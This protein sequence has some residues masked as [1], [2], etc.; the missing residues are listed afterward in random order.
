MVLGSGADK[1]LHGTK[2]LAGEDLQTALKGLDIAEGLLEEVAE[3]Y[4]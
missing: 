3:R 1:G 2:A 4:E